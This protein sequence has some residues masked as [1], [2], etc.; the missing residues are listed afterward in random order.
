MD[1]LNILIVGFTALL[2]ALLLL[3]MACK[4]SRPT[5]PAA[6][7]PTRI[8]SEGRDVSE[9]PGLWDESDIIE[10]APVVEPVAVIEVAP[11][12]ASPKP[13]A[14]AKAMP[15]PIAITIQPEQESE[16]AQSP[17]LTSPELRK[18]C[19]AAGVKWRSVNGGK[20][21]S[22]AQMRAALNL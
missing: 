15:S 12:V 16:P 14:A 13:R 21:L 6:P 19:S 7:L 4:L 1:I 17:K 5:R 8:D 11:V 10:P 3:D 2:P 20:H 18:L 22:V 9:L